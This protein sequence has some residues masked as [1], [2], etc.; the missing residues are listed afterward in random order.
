MLWYRDEQLPEVQPGTAG[1]ALRWRLPSGHRIHQM[2]TNPAYAGALADGRTEAKTVIED[3][4]A[5]QRTRRKKPLAQ[6]RLLI[7]DHHPGSISWEEFLDNQ[8]TGEANR[9]MPQEGAGGAAKR[10]PALLSGVRRWGRCGRT[11]QVAYS[12]TTGRG[13]RSVCTGGRVHRGS[14]AC[15]TIGGLRVAQAVAAAVLAAIQPAGVQAAVA[16]RERVV[17]AHDTKRQALELVLEKARYDAQRAR[18]QYDLVAPEYRLVAGELERRWNAARERVTE[19]EAQ[20]ATLESHQIALS[21]EQ[22]QG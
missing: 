4:R 7:L 21:A 3:G 22:Q 8:Q 14:S 15:L 2:L 13:P 10:G 20:L 9:H 6:W 17:A 1:R 19:V 11:L 18:R 16:A 12:G 5:R